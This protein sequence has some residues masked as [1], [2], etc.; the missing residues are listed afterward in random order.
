MKAYEDD[1]MQ[2]TRDNAL[3]ILKYEGDIEDTVVELRRSGEMLF[4]Y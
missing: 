3:D 1:R 4:P 2:E